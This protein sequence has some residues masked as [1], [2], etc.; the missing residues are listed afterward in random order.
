VL[1][2]SILQQV[3]LCTSKMNGDST[4]TRM[5][6]DLSLTNVHLSGIRIA[7]RINGHNSLSVSITADES[8]HIAELVREDLLQANILPY[9]PEQVGCFVPESIFILDCSSLKVPVIQNGILTHEIVGLDSLDL[10]TVIVK[11]EFTIDLSIGLSS[12]QDA[13]GITYCIH[14]VTG[15][16]LVPKV[17]DNEQEP[18]WLNHRASGI[19][20]QQ[21]KDFLCTY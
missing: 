2:K 17:I 7:R 6:K 10:S 11:G 5:L 4:E 1:L 12:K 8:D 16:G 3:A 21:L 13:L 18:N 15:S 20:D 9:V 19:T 14:R